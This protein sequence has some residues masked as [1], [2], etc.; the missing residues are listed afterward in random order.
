MT[1][2]PTVTLREVDAQTWRSCI[3]LAVRPDQAE[4]VSPVCRYLALCAYDDG[5]WAP[6]AVLATRVDAE[7]RRGE[8]LDRAGDDVVGFVMW[9]IDP[10]D[11]SFWIGGL[12]IDAARQGRGLGRATVDVLVE[13]ARAGDH[14]SVALS[15]QPH[16]PARHLYAA[17][18][19]EE[20]GE[21]EGDEIVARRAL[22]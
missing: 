22:S 6:L 4:F 12:V 17:L 11:D 7:P 15:Y 8:A 21:R 13:H 2:A 19:F 10:G 18:G 14:P 9:G 5:P 1:P 20:T 16:N 3:D